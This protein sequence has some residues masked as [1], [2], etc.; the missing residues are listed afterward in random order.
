MFLDSAVSHKPEERDSRR[1]RCYKC[2]EN[3]QHF[4]F[5]SWLK[6][7]ELHI[8]QLPGILLM[9]FKKKEKKRKGKMESQGCQNEI[10][11]SQ[12]NLAARW[13]QAKVHDDL[14]VFLGSL[15]IHWSLGGQWTS[16]SW[17]PVAWSFTATFAIWEGTAPSKVQHQQ[18][19]ALCLLFTV[20]HCH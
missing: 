19:P 7:I 6:W 12:M 5:T 8:F 17:W 4:C 13:A 2:I 9:W 15:V 11:I 10:L 20:I 1:W 14:K 18:L 3:C 16:Q